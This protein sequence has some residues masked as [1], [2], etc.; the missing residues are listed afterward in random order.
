LFRLPNACGLSDV[1]LSEHDDLALLQVSANL[2]VLPAGRPDLNTI[3]ALTSDR[4]E[5]LLE[6]LS[7]EFDWILLDAAPVWFMPDAQLLARMTGAV[8]FVIG[9][10]STPYPLVEKAIAAVGAESVIG[11]VLNRVIDENIPAAGYA[12]DETR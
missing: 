8:L 1:L 5:D 10:G 2:S 3:A 4:M 9:A 11:T 12:T 7:G 6:H